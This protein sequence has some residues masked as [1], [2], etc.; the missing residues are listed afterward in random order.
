MIFFSTV[1]V[2]EVPIKKNK[3]CYFS[4]L[5][6]YWVYYLHAQWRRHCGYQ[7]TFMLTLFIY[8]QNILTAVCIFFSATRA[9]LV[10]LCKKYTEEEIIVL[11]FWNVYFSHSD[12]VFKWTIADLMSNLGQRHMYWTHQG[13]RLHV[14]GL[15]SMK[16][17]Y[18]HISRLDLLESFIIGNDFCM[19]LMKRN[20]GVMLYKEF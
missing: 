4:N 13:K 8:L 12:A 10:S 6:R 5:V 17:E 15:I 14:Q 11:G 2:S 1:L 19:K 3:D 18:I 7:S 9:L 16:Y 20:S